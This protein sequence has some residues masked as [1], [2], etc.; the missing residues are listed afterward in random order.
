MSV[1]SPLGEAGDTAFRQFLQLFAEPESIVR[2]VTRRL[3]GV[4]EPL[5]EARFQCRRIG[6]LMLGGAGIL[7]QCAHRPK[8][9]A[10]IRGREDQSGDPHHG[11]A[12]ERV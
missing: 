3:A 6:P 11:S 8:L 12:S 5:L 2:P 1:Q 10:D 4:F 9:A 7:G